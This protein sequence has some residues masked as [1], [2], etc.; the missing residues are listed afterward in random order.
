MGSEAAE[1][2]DAPDSE[3]G[4]PWQHGLVVTQGV[5]VRKRRTGSRSG[6]ACSDGARVSRS[7]Q[8]RST[9][10]VARA[11]GGSSGGPLICGGAG[12]EVG[13]T[14]PDDGRITSTPPDVNAPLPFEYL[15]VTHDATPFFH[16]LPT[17]NEQD[18]AD[19]AGRAWLGK[20][21]RDPMPTRPS[22][23]PDEVP[24]VVKVPQLGLLRDEG[25]R[26]RAEPATIHPDQ[27]RHLRAGISSRPLKGHRSGGRC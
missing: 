3:A 10:A 24:A 26:T 19:A 4:T 14:P 15:K 17:F 11:V 20:H 21:G 1:A 2:D 12:V 27:P 16:R 18:D 22:D 5:F 9:A 23:R 8:A 13:E 6:L 25:G 7:R